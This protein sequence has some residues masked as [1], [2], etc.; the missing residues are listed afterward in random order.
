MES[1]S[2][3]T[4]VLV[5]MI[6]AA[7]VIILALSALVLSLLAEVTILRTV[8]VL[9]DTS[10]S[11]RIRGS[12]FGAEDNDIILEIG[13]TGQP[14]LVTGKEYTVTKDANGD[15]IILALGYRYRRF[16]DVCV[17]LIRELLL[18]LPFLF[19]DGWIYRVTHHQ[20]HLY[21]MR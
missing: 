7:R 4:N 3:F 1:T 16:C 17:N 13:V 6:F 2:A 19:T 18:S 8:T 12:G 5:N 9:Y 15:G 14:S 20:R 11:L 21:L 10:S